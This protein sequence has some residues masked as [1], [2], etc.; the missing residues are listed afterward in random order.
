MKVQ[1]GILIYYGNPSSSE[2]IH[3]SQA[4]LH[5]DYA[6]LL[7]TVFICTGEPVLSALISDKIPKGKAVLRRTIT[8]INRI[9][10]HDA[11]ESIRLDRKRARSP[12]SYVAWLLDP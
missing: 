1:L 11:W 5:D 7:T 8:K 10:R 6:S 12:K 9:D 4:D 3:T 2:S